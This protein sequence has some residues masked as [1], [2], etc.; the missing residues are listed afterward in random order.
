MSPHSTPL[1]LDC[2]HIC[3]NNAVKLWLE[4]FKLVG[5]AFL[6]T[7]IGLALV[8]IVRALRWQSNRLGSLQS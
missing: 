5:M 4:P 8:T 1:L 6:L 3:S 2:K 7:G